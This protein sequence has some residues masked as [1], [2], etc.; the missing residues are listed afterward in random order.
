MKRFAGIL[1]C[2]LATALAACTT[3]GGKP[4]TDQQPVL[5]TLPAPP[6]A[7][8][9]P[10]PPVGGPAFEVLSTQPNQITDRD[11]WFSANHLVPRHSEAGS[12][13]SGIPRSWDGNNLIQV[14]HGSDSTLAVYGPDLSG[15]RLLIAT[16]SQ[17][18]AFKYG[19]D[20]ANF[21]R[22]PGVPENDFTA[23][24]LLWAF[25]KDG[26]LYVSNSHR[27]YAK[28]SG[29]RNAYLTAIDIK[30]GEIRWRTGPLI[31]NAATFEV[32]NGLIVAGY[33]FTAE[34]DFVY[35]ID[36]ENGA[37]LASQKVKSAPEIIL[38]K[39]GK[40]FVRCYDTDVVLRVLNASGR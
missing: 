15:G 23:Q 24:R 22:P 2:L 6:F 25:E 21:E 27:T 11:A 13:P 31:A 33:G 20:F 19:F 37:V 8:A 32:L 26:T 1:G 35:L 34:P 3:S 14:I 5:E 39:D 18:G 36:R 38:A 30:S 29:G 10:S 28:E 17:T 7:A 4:A 9:P 40:I 16:D 12:A